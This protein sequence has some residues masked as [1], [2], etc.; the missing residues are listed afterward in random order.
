LSQQGGGSVIPGG[1]VLSAGPGDGIGVGESSEGCGFVFGEEL[2]YAQVEDGDVAFWKTSGEC[3]EAGSGEGVVVVVVCDEGGGELCRVRF[4][5]GD[6]SAKDDGRDDRLWRRKFGD[7]KQGLRQIGF[8]DGLRGL[9]RGD[10]EGWRQMVG[11]GEEEGNDGESSGDGRDCIPG[12]CGRFLRG[13]RDDGVDSVSRRRREWLV[14]Q[15]SEILEKH[16][17][18]FAFSEV[19]ADAG[20]CVRGQDGFCMCAEHGEWKTCGNGSNLA[21]KGFFDFVEVRHLRRPH[22]VMRMVSIST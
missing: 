19:G 12:S 11:G 5:G 3:A 20:I 18:E 14:V 17:A 9:S 2:D 8:I 16:P 15:R 21:N 7:L 10:L 22:Q 13:D 4:A 6:G 1:R